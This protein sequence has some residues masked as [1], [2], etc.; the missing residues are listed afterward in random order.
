MFTVKKK[1]HIE[2]IKLALLLGVINVINMLGYITAI[3]YIDVATAALLLYMAP[4]Y[5]VPLSFL[6]LQEKIKQ[7]VFP[8]IAIAFVGLI[9]LLS[10]HEMNGN[11]GIIY[12]TIGGIAC[13]FIFVLTKM[14]RERTS[15][16]TIIF[17][18]MAISTIILSPSILTINFSQVNWVIA[19]GMGLIPTVL[20]YFC[21]VYGIKYCKAQEASIL[22]LFEPI[23]VIIFGFII[24]KESL[25]LSQIIG[26]ILILSGIALME[27]KIILNKSALKNMRVF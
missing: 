5:V 8:T 21:Y 19:V 25:T 24:L 3:K 9:L 16:I 23:S 27:G 14:L 13:A 18:Q 22:A 12:G 2:N 15:A 26:A 6:I 7:R 20:A 10:V 17:Y 4:I 11:I 1:F